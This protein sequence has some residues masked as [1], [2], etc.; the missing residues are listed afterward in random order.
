MP[1]IHPPFLLKLSS[2]ALDI[3]Q[4]TIV[5]RPSAAIKSPYVADMTIDGPQSVL[6]HTP[7]LG[8][9]GLCEPKSNVI[10]VK[11]VQKKKSDDQKPKCQYRVCL[12]IEGNTMICIYPKLAENVVEKAIQ[13]NYIR[14]LSHVKSY[15][16]ETTID[17]A[18]R[19]LCRFDFS[20]VDSDGCAFLLEVK[21]VPLSI[22]NN[23]M[24]VSYFPDGYRKKPTDPV[25]P[26]A[27]KHVQELEHI[28]MEKG[29]SIRCILCFVVQRSDTQAFILGEKDP[30]YKAAV[31]KAREN[32][33]EILILQIHWTRDGRAYF[34]NDRLPWVD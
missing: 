32:G 9:C 8:C 10:A 23:N 16:R 30:E 1:I 33:V 12:S 25:S 14:S 6:A 27:L 7:S 28:K 31:I 15:E 17:F 2:S 4:G 3:K 21:A 13:K 5:K 19:P 34:V 22:T 11:I 26:R 29:D 24:K 18:D 20:G